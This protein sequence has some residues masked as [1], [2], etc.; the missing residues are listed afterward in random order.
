MPMTQEPAIA[1]NAIRRVWEQTIVAFVL[2]LSG[3]STV[4]YK[5]D[6]DSMRG[7]TVA[8]AEALAQKAC[9]NRNDV[10]LCLQYPFSTKNGR[11]ASL[12]A[13]GQALVFYLDGAK[14][15]TFPYEN[16]P[17]RPNVS[18]NS[19]DG[20]YI[21][22]GDTE[23]REFSGYLFFRLGPDSKTP[24]SP[25]SPLL[26]RAKDFARAYHFLWWT[27]FNASPAADR[28]EKPSAVVVAP[29]TPPSIPD[30]PREPGTNIAVADLQATG[31][32]ANDAAVIADLLRGELVKI[33]VYSVV[34]K[35]NM[36]KILAEQAFQQTGCTNQEC[37]VKL[38]K[39]LNVQRMI[40]GSCGE[41]LGKY[42]VNIRVVDVETSKVTFAD[43][44][45][46]R[47]VEEIQ[48]GI[49]V[50]A[51]NVSGRR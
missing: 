50:M 15:A 4:L 18:C 26:A 19:S 13:N 16:Q 35:K 37:A 48:A 10:D 30:R 44:A 7:L 5:P 31:M 39:M 25:D 49:K 47:T 22:L 23:K 21:M 9:V 46:G 34:E 51:R 32:S 12:S 3:C 2:G 45:S 36:D 1:R 33:G 38:G 14:P 41:L 17:L 40:V 29:V 6:T 8:S 24:L 20:I 42:F 11:I 27:H 43:E 28:P